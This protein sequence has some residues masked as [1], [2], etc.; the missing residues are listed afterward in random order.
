MTHDKARELIEELS[1]RIDYHRKKYY[2]EDA[3]EITD[4]EFDSLM[5]ELK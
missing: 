2:L 3:P 5:H 4:D 1:L